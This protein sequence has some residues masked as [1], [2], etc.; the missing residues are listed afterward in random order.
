MNYYFS[1]L[2][3]V[4]I[5]VKLA[6]IQRLDGVVKIIETFHDDVAGSKPAEAFCFFEILIILKWSKRDE[7]LTT[8]EI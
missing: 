3:D 1:H 5:S 7:P 2:Q 6:S 8:L 4:Y